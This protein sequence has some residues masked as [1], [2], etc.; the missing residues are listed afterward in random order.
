VVLC[1]VVAAA[2]GGYAL[3]GSYA[4][5]ALDLASASGAAGRAAG[6]R[7]RSGGLSSPA[8]Q[9]K[10]PSPSASPSKSPSPR[11]SSPR[12]APPPRPAPTHTV[13]TTSW[14]WCSSAPSGT[15]NTLDGR[16][17]LF[18]NEWNTS[19]NPGPQTICGNSPSDWQV[20]STQRAGNGEILTYPS[21]QVNYNGGN[22]DPLSDFTTMTS[23][24]AENMNAV[25]G[26][27]AEAAYDIWINGLNKE[28]MVWVDNHDQAPGGSR[29]ATT[30]FSGST[31]G[32]YETSDKSYMAFVREGN[33]PAGTVDLHAALAYLEGRGDLSASDTLWQVNFGWEIASTAGGPET[34]TL[35][36]YSLDSSPSS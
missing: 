33:A 23:S 12:P 26:T 2:F 14:A 32:L 11:P 8:Q 16:F 13:V 17:D 1:V 4:G 35:S 29:V 6:L 19:A 30:S 18:N 9:P 15:S 3:A 5:K 10:L 28:V 25:G 27:D 34:F 20:T 36:N 31:W 22:G 24:Y 21:V 7:L